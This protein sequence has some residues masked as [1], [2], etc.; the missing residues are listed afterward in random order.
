MN[1][2][3]A[4]NEAEQRYEQVDDAYKASHFLPTPSFRP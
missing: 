1:I 4:R 3:P 2:K